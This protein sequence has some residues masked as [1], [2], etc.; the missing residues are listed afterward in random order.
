MDFLPKDYEAP[1]SSSGYMKLQDGENKFRILS[2]P[3]VGWEDWQDKKP[4]R[5]PMDQK[6]A[7]PIDEKKPIKHFWAMIV[8]NYAEADI[9][10]LEITQ[11][12]IRRA[13]EGLC[14]DDDWGA[15][16]FYDIKVSRQGEGMKTEYSISPVPH[17]PLAPHI[18]Q[19]FYEKRCNLEALF[20]G[21]D[22]FNKEYK[23]YTDGVFSKDEVKASSK[24]ESI[25]CERPVNPLDELPF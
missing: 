15:P 18:Q 9:Q 14:S 17:K 2:A 20:H 8:W 7:K 11:T 4:I 25:P 16:Y 3:I 23:C 22:P 21:E 13:I 12:S 6:P 5:F 1:K 19:R 24:V 10:I